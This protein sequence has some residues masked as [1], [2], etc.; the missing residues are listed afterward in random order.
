MFF[1]RIENNYED[2]FELIDDIGNSQEFEVYLQSIFSPE[3]G[4]LLTFEEIWDQNY[5]GNAQT[6]MSIKR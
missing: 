3:N 1:V 2:P 5:D 6:S 4:E